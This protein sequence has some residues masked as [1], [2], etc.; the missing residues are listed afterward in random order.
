[1]RFRHLDGEEGGGTSGNAACAQRPLKRDTWGTKI[2]DDRWTLDGGEGGVYQKN[3]GI[4]CIPLRHL[5]S[6]TIKVPCQNRSG[7]KAKRIAS[8]GSDPYDIEYSH[9]PPPL[10]LRPRGSLRIPS[11]RVFRNLS[12][13]WIITR[14]HENGRS[15]SV[16]GCIGRSRTL[17]TSPPSGS[18]RV[19]PPLLF[20]EAPSL[21][22]LMRGKGKT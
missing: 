1:M 4:K 2:P 16:R 20:E 10:P 15:D 22:L 8:N 6:Y 3:A 17:R 11:W 21:H 12:L 18:P 7:R 5:F 14:Y 19:R 9:T 13:V